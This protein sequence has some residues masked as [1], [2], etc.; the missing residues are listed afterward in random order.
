MRKGKL[1]DSILV[2]H[3]SILPSVDRCEL[4]AIV[5]RSAEGDYVV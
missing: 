1:I 5:E 4:K 2:I 3:N